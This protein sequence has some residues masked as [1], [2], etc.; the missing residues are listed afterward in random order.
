MSCP[1]NKI[2][3]D[4]I[5][6]ALEVFQG[7]A[8]SIR[9]NPIDKTATIRWGNEYRVKT[10]QQ[11]FNMVNS[12]IRRVQKWS[13]EEFN[14]TFDDWITID[15]QDNNRVVIKARFPKDLE[16]SYVLRLARDGDEESIEKIK[17]NPGY[18]G[19]GNLQDNEGI[20]GPTLYQLSD[21]SNRKALI[22][23]NK[24]IKRRMEQNGIKVQNDL[25]EFRKAYKIKT[26][27]DFNAVAF[28]DIGNNLIRY[29]RGE[30]LP[31]DALLEEAVHFMVWYLWD[32]DHM[33]AIRNTKEGS[34]RWIETTPEWNTYYDQYR[35]LYETQEKHP[36][37]QKLVEQEIV[38]K[39][40]TTDIYEKSRDGVYNTH[41]SKRWINYIKNL[42][43]KIFGSKNPDG[44]PQFNFPQEVEKE[45]GELGKSL[46]EGTLNLPTSSAN[47][48]ELLKPNLVPEEAGTMNIR[49][50]S[51][52]S[53]LK[54]TRTKYVNDQLGIYNRQHKR[55]KKELEAKYGIKDV[56]ELEEH[57]QKLLSDPKD[58]YL[59]KKMLK[60]LF[61]LEELFRR[62][63]EDQKIVDQI[64]DLNNKIL[65]LNEQIAQKQVQQGILNLLMGDG[66]ELTS[67]GTYKTTGS[68]ADKAD[69]LLKELED[70]ALE[71]SQGSRVLIYP[72]AIKAK[73]F[74]DNFK[75]LIKQLTT[76]IDTNSKQKLLEDLS[77][78]DRENF[79]YSLELTNLRL[80][81]LKR[82]LDKHWASSIRIEIMNMAIKNSDGE[83]LFEDFTEEDVQRIVT[84]QDP[85]YLEFDSWKYTAM[86]LSPMDLNVKAIQAAVRTHAVVDARVH[87]IVN[88][89]VIDYLNLVFS[90]RED[91][92]KNSIIRKY[93]KKYGLNHPE[94]LVMEIGKDKLPTGYRLGR[95]KT[96]AFMDSYTKHAETVYIQIEDFIKTN[97]GYTLNIP[98]GETQEARKARYNLFY[99][100]ALSMLSP[101]DRK[102]NLNPIANLQKQLWKPWYKNNTQRNPQAK[103][104]EDQARA[105]MSELEFDVWWQEN[106]QIFVDDTGREREYPSGMLILPT[107]DYLNESYEELTSIPKFKQILDSY[108]SIKQ[109]ADDSLP[110]YFTSSYEF[111]ERLPQLSNDNWDMVNRASR[112]FK[113][114]VK[115]RLRELGSVISERFTVTFTAKA[116]DDFTARGAAQGRDPSLDPVY[117]PPIRFTEKL[118]SNAALS[119]DVIGN[120]AIY[121]EMA[122]NYREMSS[123]A[124]FMEALKENVARTTF[125]VGTEPAFKG[126]QKRNREKHFRT[127][128][129]DKSNAFKVVDN[130]IMDRI[131]GQTVKPAKISIRGR[132]IDGT[133]TLG[134]MAKFIRDANLKSN[135][136]AAFSGKL[137]ASYESINEVI[138]GRII[139]PKA[140][141]FA[142][143]EFNKNL[144]AL[145]KDFESPIKKNKYSILA[146]KIDLIDTLKDWSKDTDK[147]RSL[148]MIGRAI[149]Y[150]LWRG[151][152]YP[153]RMKVM[154]AVMH[155]YRFINNKWY[156]R[157]TYLNEKDEHTV[158]KWN[159]NESNSFLNKVNTTS[160]KA[161]GDQHISSAQWDFVTFRSKIIGSRISY[162]KTSYD[163]SL[164]DSWV[165]APLLFL[166]RGYLQI[167]IG[168]KFKP[169]TRDFM[170]QQ[171]TQGEYSH[172][173]DA[174]VRR[175]EGMG[176]RHLFGWDTENL[177]PEQTESIKKWWLAILGVWISWFLMLGSHGDFD[178]DQNDD[179]IQWMAYLLSRSH[180]ERTTW[181]DPTDALNQL[182]RPIAVEDKYTG[183]VSPLMSDAELS[184]KKYSSKLQKWYVENF[185]YGRL[186]QSFPFE[187]PLSN[188][189]PYSYDRDKRLVNKVLQNNPL[190][191]WTWFDEVG[192]DTEG[193]IIKD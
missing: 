58:D 41:W 114:N 188:S 46:I 6:K 110:A 113:G 52:L 149:N 111:R 53:R 49:G 153:M 142:D 164:A 162:Q 40:I 154:I 150:G 158:E 176:F 145:L 4:K 75:P 14:K 50:N 18:Y 20:K 189:A 32:T 1:L 96:G 179:F 85:K 77:E 92:N 165:I 119:L 22:G 104:I 65:K 26:G 185:P 151:L 133:K 126:Y 138:G 122:I 163:R 64:Q 102:N 131:Y 135:F 12:N 156:D 127:I 166:H 112:I 34:K 108:N 121:Y 68:I 69:E 192:D 25:E 95:Y 76:D 48:L 3:G 178:D 117:T 2:K 37:W 174:I 36:E 136:I 101:E 175:N 106:H 190:M 103:E 33:T 21:Q 62:S 13:K 81:A 146:Q 155:N 16:K 8:K 63:E 44:T 70:V 79:I 187:T 84:S 118:E 120:L 67:E 152:D 99:E 60:E 43:K 23:L 148:N 39:I 184:K 116:D 73:I 137:S 55:R 181:T 47:K 45:L 172:T 129:G 82:A 35:D 182:M 147:L 107:D 19:V 139:D 89:R 56:K 66:V 11:A 78:E 94:Q 93:L 7:D 171:I 98:R 123:A 159:N 86:F 143:N 59:H 28:A 27:K 186:Y 157:E 177:H 88:D 170:M 10:R 54:N 71:Q 97:Y 57:I 74:L 161:I 183:I 105:I 128:S 140:A 167:G 24:I 169:R 144:Q 134:F 90:N 83:N 100:D 130:L 124:P 115:E 31:G 61:R 30:T 38:T 15:G 160:G 91:L 87:R 173:L 180:Q 191:P 168:K 9:V 42:I 125:K 80:G 51:I 132:T 17:K 193:I 141:I 72:A 5:N 29:G 109:E